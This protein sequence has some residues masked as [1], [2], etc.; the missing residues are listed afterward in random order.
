MATLL[1]GIFYN[2]VLF[3]IIFITAHLMALVHPKIRKGIVAR[4]GVKRD[5]QHF[6]ESLPTERPNIYL[7]HCA[8]LGEFEHIKPFLRRLKE[9][10]PNSKTVVMF[11][12]PS[13]YE[14][15]RDFPLVDL[16]IYS[17]FDWWLPTIKLFRALNPR[18]LLIAKY[19][20]WPNQMWAAC[21]L[22]IPRI[23]INATLHPQSRRLHFP[24]KWFL[25]PIYKHLDRVLAIS[26]LDS[27]LYQQ[28]VDKDKIT[29]VGDS[30][31][32]QVYTRYQESQQK[33]VLPQRMLEQKFVFVAGSTWEE[34]EEHL[35]PAIKNI[36]QINQDF[37]AIICPHEPTP[38]HLKE[39]RNQLAPLPVCAYSR[40][41]QYQGESIILIDGVGLLA[42]L[43]AEAHVAYVGGSFKQN[44]HN[45]L[46]PAVY[47][48]PVLM[49]PV[50]RNS[51][52]AQMLKEAR[53]AI[54]V[55]SSGDIVKMLERF[56]VDEEHR[57]KIGENARRVVLEHRGATERIY[58]IIFSEILKEVEKITTPL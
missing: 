41:N 33:R 4:Y 8:S 55:G 42:N 22:G 52:E 30:K 24:A 27:F 29:T 17:P 51:I 35:I 6:L 40:L 32:D 15:T 26:E 12:S 18:A 49:G 5:V 34:D 54:E 1:L 53:G 14:H 56:L 37:L 19:D 47:G 58:K 39:L 28:L 2:L 36:I 16:T 25:R 10:H 44:I 21:R 46:E 57:L 38:E 7:F 3:P 31:F 45:V 9:K 43:Y 50:N 13:G 20:V 48:I 11:F 23:L